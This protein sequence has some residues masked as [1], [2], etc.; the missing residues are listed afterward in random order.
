[1]NK[2]SGN[3]NDGLKNDGYQNNGH[4][5]GRIDITV[6]GA[7]VEDILAGPVDPSVFE[8]GSMPMDFIKT[9][10]GGDALNEA[11]I[12]S[13]L[14]AKTELITKLGKDD[15]GVRTADFLKENNVKIEHAVCTA[16][17]PSSV[18]IVLIDEN[19]ERYFL[20]NPSSC[21]RKLSEEDILPYVNK[22]AD[23]VSFASIF[24]SPMLD[25]PTL[26]RLFDAITKHKKILLTD[27]TKPKKGEKLENLLGCLPYIDFFLTNEDE[28]A[29][30]TDCSDAYENARRIVNAGAGC[31][32]IKCGKNGCIIRNGEET[33][34]I[35]AYQ[36]CR[37]VD[38]T[39][40]GDS[41]AA[42]FLYGL[43]RGFSI[44][45]CGRFACAVASCV[46]EKVGGSESLDSIDEPMRRFENFDICVRIHQ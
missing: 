9:S 46:V 40:A 45:D 20:T 18:N 31:A 41:F 28:A 3:K 1:M 44:K 24:V 19:G 32:V 42:G 27:M 15:V 11:V 39:G 16:E 14:G 29:M 4:K 7:A 34:E 2:N 22:M 25:I 5:N 33:I 12:L 10:F 21:L 36:G 23:I 30:L 37:A 17:Y 43:S 6:I 8:I 13:R 38:T 26:E 35:P